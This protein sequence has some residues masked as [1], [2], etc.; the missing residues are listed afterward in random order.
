MKEKFFPRDCG[1]GGCVGGRHAPPPRISA[2]SAR[3]P[4]VNKR[5]RR[6]PV[7][8]FGGRPRGSRSPR[9]RKNRLVFPPRS[10]KCW[11]NR[12]L[13]RARNPESVGRCQKWRHRD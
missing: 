1:G 7:S 6:A 13:R 12:R 9:S 11:R 3:R 5:P 4:A 8:Y 10:G 2:R